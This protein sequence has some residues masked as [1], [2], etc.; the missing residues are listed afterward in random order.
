MTDIIKTIRKI[1]DAMEEQQLAFA[2]FQKQMQRTQH[3]I[4]YGMEKLKQHA[5]EEDSSTEDEVSA[6]CDKLKKKTG[7]PSKSTM[8]AVDT[9]RLRSILRK[10]D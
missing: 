10:Q 6:L 2:A 8:A 7:K 1:T 9:D 5:I 3:Y 4:D